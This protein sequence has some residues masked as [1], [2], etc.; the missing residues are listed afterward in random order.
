[1]KSNI[2]WLLGKSFRMCK[3]IPSDRQTKGPEFHQIASDFPTYYTQFVLFL[4][5][6]LNNVLTYNYL[7]F[8]AANTFWNSWHIGA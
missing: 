7:C 1:M 3:L 8:A 5:K 2:L 6:Y 4:P